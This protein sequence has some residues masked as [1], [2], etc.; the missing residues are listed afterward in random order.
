MRYTLGG[1]L[2]AVW[3]ELRRLEYLWAYQ[4]L[5]RRDGD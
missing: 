3:Y 4:S 5:Y 1:Y 2:L